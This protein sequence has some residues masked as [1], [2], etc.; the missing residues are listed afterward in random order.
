MVAISPTSPDTTQILTCSATF[1]AVDADGESVTVSYGWTKDGVA[2]GTGSTI[3]ASATAKG[4]VWQCTASV[5][6]G[7]TS[8]SATSAVTIQNSAPGAPGIAIAPTAPSANA[9]L[10]CTATGAADADND[11]V[12]YTYRWLKNQAPSGITTAALAKANTTPGDVWT[13]EATPNDGVDSGPMA[14]ADVIIG[15]TAPVAPVVSISRTSPDTT[16]ILTCNATYAAVDVDGESVTVSY[17]WTKDGVA[18]GTGST[19]AASATAKGQVWQC[20]ASVSDGWTS[21]SSASSVTIQNSAPT[22]PQNALRPLRITTEDD[23]YCR[24]DQ[25]STD[26]D[27][28]SL[29]YIIGW[30]LNL[31]STGNTT[32]WFSRTQTAVGDKLDCGARAFDGTD[33]S[34]IITA[35]STVLAP[36]E[37]WGV[38]F[39]GDDAAQPHLELPPLTSVTE[40]TLEGW[41][42]PSQY[43]AE[44]MAFGDDRVRC[45]VAGAS[46]FGADAQHWMCEIQTTAGTVTLVSLS[47]IT[48]Q[49]WQ[50][51]S[52]VFDG[53]D[54]VLFI[55]GVE[56]AREAAGGAIVASTWSS[57][58]IGGHSNAG[59]GSTFHGM[60][61]DFRMTSVAA[62]T[63]PFTP[64][65]RQQ[66]SI[67][68]D[69]LWH[70]NEGTGPAGAD[71]ANGESATLTNGAVWVRIDDAI[72]G[73]GTVEIGEMCD[74]G[75]LDNTDECSNQCQS[76]ACLTQARVS[77]DGMV[78]IDEL[79]SQKPANPAFLSMVSSAVNIQTMN[80]KFDNLSV[81]DR[82]GMVLYSD[83]FGAQGSW[84]V[85]KGAIGVANI[86]GGTAN[87]GSDW[88]IFDLGGHAFDS[89]NGLVVSADTYWSTVENYYG[90][91]FVNLDPTVN[92][93]AT[94][95][96]GGGFDRQM[97]A[98]LNGP[99]VAT[100]F[101]N[102]VNGGG[103]L[104]APWSAPSAGWHRIKVE[105]L[106]AGCLCGNGI[107]DENE[108]CDDGN[109]DSHDG[110]SATCDVEV[111]GAS[112]LEI[113]NNGDSTGDGLYNI[114][115]D[116]AGPR[117][118]FTAYCDMT[119]DGGGWMRAINITSG[120]V[121][122]A[123]NPG[124]YGDISNANE[125]AKMSD[126]D[127]TALNTVGYWRWYCGTGKRAFVRNTAA[128]FTSNLFNSYTWFMDNNRDGI[129][130]CAASRS[131]YGFSDYPACMAGH[132]D[133][134]AQ[135]GASEGTG[136][137]VF[138]EGWS[139][140]GSLWVK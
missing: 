61:D 44:G 8:T 19:I 7:W 20:T 56:N 54:F 119:V 91:Y 77:F 107:L 36:D 21:T 121:A 86:S 46:A 17:A 35:S 49:S 68:T 2:A 33:S 67:S 15:N 31:S 53:V 83:T 42:K 52:L 78:F 32:P 104:K 109:L 132:S 16:Q 97:Y 115:V 22:A 116:G 124:S 62:H 38:Y 130:E 59:A 136:C 63:G 85:R 93:A 108:T 11:I 24:V 105:F 94:S 131:G 126:A 98:S 79:I 139:R 66:Y 39:N 128:T 6:D 133:Y 103:F 80:S 113:L 129:F 13:C 9:D 60:V 30:V 89:S 74:D 47:A 29:S 26:A 28:D 92:L 137:A 84:Q 64:E 65:R 75:D 88:N 73:N 57:F 112:C 69:W 127:I 25:T 118:L 114:D 81:Q 87:G 51:I 41:F 58:G 120:S 37:N 100:V 138:G 34:S 10:V 43:T 102:M 55:D 3:A 48:L 90:F 71:D 4:Q 23:V 101:D 27:N 40:F 82:D 50:H 117:P 95:L 18:A 45:F 106:P 96:L 76:S 125:A 14:T 111:V 135:N 12:T 99:A 110:C 72:C 140:S 5:S 70:L 122:H 123:N 1:D 134:G